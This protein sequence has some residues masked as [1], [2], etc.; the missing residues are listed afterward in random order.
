M[1]KWLL[2]S[3]ELIEGGVRDGEKGLRAKILKQRGGVAKDNWRFHRLTARASK[4][5]SVGEEEGI[6]VWEW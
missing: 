5:S 6:I 3:Q 1:S 4:H 2:K